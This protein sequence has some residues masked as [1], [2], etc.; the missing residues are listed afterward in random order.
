ME[1]VADQQHSLSSRP[2]EI[3]RHDVHRTGGRPPLR[4]YHDGRCWNALGDQIALP[5]RRFTH[6]V[7]LNN[8][9][10]DD[11][12]VGE[13]FAVEQGGVVESCLK[14]WRGTAIVLGGTEDDNSLG[15]RALIAT[16]DHE[17]DEEA[18]EIDTA[19]SERDRSEPEPRGDCQKGNDSPSR[20]TITSRTPSSRR[21]VTIVAT[22]R[23]SPWTTNAR[24]IGPPRARTHVRISSPPACPE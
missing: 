7:T 24:L 15:V 8:S 21:M 23:S 6:A 9:A 19:D 5:C 11:N 1:R 14:D 20:G 18:E 16:R 13:L 10:G 2:M 12:Q 17:Y 4:L 3:L 22:A